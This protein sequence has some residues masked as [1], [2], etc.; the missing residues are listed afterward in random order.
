MLR[1][2]S[3]FNNFKKVV[4]V[5]VAYGDEYKP[6][7]LAYMLRAETLCSI[8]SAISEPSG[9]PLKPKKILSKIKELVS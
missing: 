1:L 2:K 6:A 7:P 9:C 5:E 4:T 3:L 8:D